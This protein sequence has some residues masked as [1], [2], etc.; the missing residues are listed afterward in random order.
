MLFKWA[1]YVQH[2]QVQKYLI[3]CLA[4]NLKIPIRYRLPRIVS[5]IKIRY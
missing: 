2:G 3:F 5:K 4:E 1:S